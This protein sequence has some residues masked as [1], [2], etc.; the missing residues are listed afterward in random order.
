MSANAGELSLTW[1]RS[2]ETNVTG[3]FLYHGP[4]PGLATNLTD[5]VRLDVGSTN[6][7]SM[8]VMQIGAP[9][10]FS[11]TAYEATGLESGHSIEIAYI[12]PWVNASA[13]PGVTRF[14]FLRVRENNNLKY[15]LEFTED[16]VTWTDQFSFVPE[17]IE[18]P[19]GIEHYKVD[20]PNAVTPKLFARVKVEIR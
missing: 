15:S 2:P 20:I 6:K 1:E 14:E 4:R 12:V 7:I 17:I 10:W 11:V 9:K 16:F 19:G 18:L 13:A 5:R 3:Y 8:P